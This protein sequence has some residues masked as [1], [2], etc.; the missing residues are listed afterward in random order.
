EKAE[1]LVF[2]VWRF[3]LIFGE[4]DTISMASLTVTAMGLVT[5]KK[6]VLLHLGVRPGDMIYVD[7]LPGGKLDFI[8]V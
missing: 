6:E 1:A 5:L 7:L 8:S 4:K 2:K 3:S